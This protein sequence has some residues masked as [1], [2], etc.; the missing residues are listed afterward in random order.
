MADTIEFYFDF[1]SPY[2]YLACHRIDE[3]AAKY[4][5]EVKWRAYLIGAVFQINGQ[6]PLVEQPLKGDYSVHDLERSARLHELAFQLPDPFPIPT[7]AAGRVFYYLDDQ[8]PALAKKFARAALTAYFADNVDIRP[9]DVV[10]GIAAGVGADGAACIAATD[11][12][13]YKDRLR[14]ETEAAIENGAF[15]SPYVIVDGE[16]FWG[17][18][19]LD[20]VDKWLE[21]GGW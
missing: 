11:D 3:I 13:V 9:R 10:G 19:R 8:D 12:Q 15:G 2:G 16:P 21:R 6:R 20:M 4:G 17:N 7:Q 14:A 5:R 1:S 18:D